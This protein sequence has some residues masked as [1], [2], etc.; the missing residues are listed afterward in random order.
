MDSLGLGRVWL[1]V[2]RTCGSATAARSGRPVGVA[3]GYTIG[4]QTGQSASESRRSSASSAMRSLTRRLPRP[5]RSSE[6]GT[7]TFPSAAMSLKPHFPGEAAAPVDADG[8]VGQ[9]NC[10]H[11]RF[12][13]AA[14]ENPL[15]FAK[16]AKHPPKSLRSAHYSAKSRRYRI[17][18]LLRRSAKM[19][20]AVSNF[21]AQG[22]IPS[23]NL[24]MR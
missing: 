1:M 8:V 11:S 17:G 16:R 23:N 7:R 19:I 22:R 10:R 18:H 15:P 9:R 14:S 13:Y 12:G 5:S 2:I 24:H 21:P 4:R 3:V 6:P 20:M